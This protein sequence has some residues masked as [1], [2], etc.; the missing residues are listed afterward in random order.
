MKKIILLGV[1]ICTLFIP[2]INAQIP[3]GF[4]YQA[5][6]R[7]SD[8]NVVQ[9]SN[10]SVRIGILQGSATA[11]AIY[12]ETHAAQANNY[13]LI[14]L[15]IGEGETSG[16]FSAI[17][18]SNSPYFI[19]L[20]V[21]LNDGLGYK[22]VGTSQ[23]LAVPY[24]LH[25][26]T[27]ESIESIESDPIY[28][29][30]V[31]SSISG[32]DTLNWNNKLDNY[33]ETQNLNDVLTQN[34]SAENNNITNL[35]DPVNAQDAATKAYVDALEARIEQLELSIGVTDVDGNIYKVVKIGNQIWMAENLKTSQ[36]QQGVAIPLVTDGTEWMNLGDNNTDMA[37]CY[38]Y[39]DLDTLAKYGALY[40]YA[41]AIEACPTGWHL[42]S[43]DDWNELINYI[44]NDG[45]SG[46]E[47]VALK[48][49]TGWENDD[50]GNSGNGT[51]DYGF[52]ALPS[53]DR[54]PIE[55]SHYS[56][57]YTSSVWWS[58]TV[59][60]VQQEANIVRLSN[61]FP[62]IPD[63]TDYEKRKSSGYSVR[64]LKD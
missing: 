25:A 46:T 41:A 27:V 51:D 54:E 60:Y 34:N 7:S 48:S 20:E 53:G 42:P 26:K 43:D 23:L 35:A 39:N 18:W 12:I 61:E 17:D 29:S 44:T 2:K 5:V 6:I 32:D 4:N 30:S 19:K 52:K 58:S 33:S 59:S 9:Q 47:A 56:G 55:D 15:V 14:N 31:A 11:S 63:I 50:Y 45:H 16:D 38:Q 3:N 1:I 57:L 28:S 36:T 21:D 10:V 40:T 64:C 24:A 13:G 49:T 62:Y 22:E 8:G 37:Y